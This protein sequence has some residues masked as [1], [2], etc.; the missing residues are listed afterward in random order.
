MQEKFSRDPRI[1]AVF[2]RK[3]FKVPLFQPSIVVKDTFGFWEETL[4]KTVLL[5][6]APC[7]L[8]LLTV[9]QHIHDAWKKGGESR[10]SLL[11]M[12]CEAGFDKENLLGNIKWKN[13]MCIKS[14]LV[15][16]QCWGSL[17]PFVNPGILM[18]QLSGCFLVKM[19]KY[20][21]C[22]QIRGRKHLQWLNDTIIYYDVSP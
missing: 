18:P 5:C 14:D 22:F 1:N 21:L 12:F 2:S 16:R 13:M 7:H 9:P 6:F 15:S 20:N 10:Q 4:W 11:K 17:S 8:R 3:Q 19:L